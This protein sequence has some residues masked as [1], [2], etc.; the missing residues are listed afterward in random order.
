VEAAGGGGRRCGGRSVDEVEQQ[1][2]GS[3]AGAPGGTH[4]KVWAGARRCPSTDSGRRRHA[5][6]VSVVGMVG[7]GGVRARVGQH[8]V[9]CVWPGGRALR[10]VDKAPYL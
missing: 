1:P 4:A 10:C 8:G 3:T 9:V 5:G 6:V 7:G 2:G